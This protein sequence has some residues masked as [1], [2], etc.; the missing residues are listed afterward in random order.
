M[1]SQ[2]GMRGRYKRSGQETGH[3]APENFGPSANV[4]G[5]LSVLACVPH[6]L[7]FQSSVFNSAPDT[8]GLTDH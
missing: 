7:G 3:E 4:W 2:N 6:R 8:F 1:I 5:L